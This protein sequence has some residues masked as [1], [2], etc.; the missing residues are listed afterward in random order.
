M[1]DD[2]AA[3]IEPL[4][5]NLESLIVDERDGRQGDEAMPAPTSRAMAQMAE[6]HKYPMPGYDRPIEGAL[7]MGR[8]YATAAE[9]HALALSRL[10]LD[11]TPI[12]YAHAPMARACLEASARAVPLLDAQIDT[13]LRV[14][15]FMNE[16]LDDLENL[17]RAIAS[18]DGVPK[19][20]KQQIKTLV[21]DIFAAGAAVGLRKVTK[22]NTPSR[23]AEPY[24]GI[25][26]RVVHLLD[27]HQQYLRPL[28]VNGGRL[29]YADLSSVTH[30]N[31][32]AVASRIR[33]LTEEEA[34]AAGAPPLEL[35]MPGMAT[36]A[37]MADSG[38]VNR[39][40][41]LSTV[42][43]V[44]ASHHRRLIYGHLSDDWEGRRRNSMELVAAIWR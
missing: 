4:R 37:V 22:K 12:V 9:D 43:V 32:H 28:E 26:A 40:L 33:E 44:L 3:A 14:A 16:R 24:A 34:S 30:A 19:S 5:A 25:T 2:F 6:E 29:L 18:I 17:K 27:D 10:C 38:L 7:T 21:D 23:L 42:A 41:A 11:R 31:K 13:A 8:M 35:T 1:P 15:R 39:A 36:G 20:A